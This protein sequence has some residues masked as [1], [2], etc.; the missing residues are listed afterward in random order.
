M[1]VLHDLHPGP[2]LEHDDHVWL[3]QDVAGGVDGDP[4]EMLY[5]LWVSIKVDIPTIDKN[6]KP[7]SPL[8]IR[9]SHPN[10]HCG[11]GVVLGG[12]RG[13]LGGEHGAIGAVPDLQ[14]DHGHAVLGQYFSPV[15]TFPEHPA[16]PWVY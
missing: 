8:G 1:H 6:I 12:N 9:L 15:Q 10:L 11:R 2:W 7:V 16:W 4:C 3:V 14:Q 5:L 13:E